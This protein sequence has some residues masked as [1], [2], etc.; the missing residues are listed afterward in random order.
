MRRKNSGI[1]LFYKLPT[2]K[3][4]LFSIFIS[5]RERYPSMLLWC[6]YTVDTHILYFATL[7]RFSLHLRCSEFKVVFQRNVFALLKSSIFFFLCFVF[8]FF[9]F[10]FLYILWKKNNTREMFSFSRVE[11]IIFITYNPELY[12][13][14]TNKRWLFKGQGFIY[15]KDV[16]Y[17]ISQTDSVK[18]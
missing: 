14:V 12:Y 8:P 16:L 3:R 17:T 9:L 7:G 10:F 15:Y 6:V 18:V 11:R 13:E 1:A 4:R 2:A 5:V